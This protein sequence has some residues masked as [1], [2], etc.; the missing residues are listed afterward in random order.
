MRAPLLAA[1]VVLAVGSGAAVAAAKERP[2]PPLGTVTCSYVEAG[3]PGPADNYVSATVRDFEVAL[4][5]N[6][7]DR[8][9]VGGAVQGEISCGTQPT[10]SNID[11]IEV[12][13]D[14]D[15]LGAIATV[16]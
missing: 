8:I 6:V 12:Q 13:A 5:R 14:R 7:G 11:R 9:A 4:F 15:S 2:F 16:D 3:V 10:V 1:A